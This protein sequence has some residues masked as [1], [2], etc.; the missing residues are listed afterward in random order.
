MGQNSCGMVAHNYA[1]QPLKVEANVR[2]VVSAISV[3][4]S[5]YY[6]CH[7]N[8]LMAV[9]SFQILLFCLCTDLFSKMFFL[10]V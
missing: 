3:N 6:V 9:P 10:V 4:F 5:M 2:V 7:Q 1:F 8:K